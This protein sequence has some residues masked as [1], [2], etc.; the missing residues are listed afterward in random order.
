MSKTCILSFLLLI[1]SISGAESNDFRDIEIR[2]NSL[3]TSTAMYIRLMREV[4][5][6]FQDIGGVRAQDI[7][8]LIA[9][10]DAVIEFSENEVKLAPSSKN[11]RKQLDSTL[12][13][14]KSFISSKQG[15]EL[16]SSSPQS[17]KYTNVP[18]SNLGSS[19]PQ[20]NK[21]KNIPFSNSALTL[22]I[23]ISSPL[24]WEKVTHWY[25]V[26]G[27]VSDPLTEIMVVIHPTEISAFWIQ[28]PVTVK[29]NGT[30][31]VLACF[32][33][34]G[35]DSGM[36][37]EICAFANPVSYFREGRFSNWPESEARSKVVSVIRK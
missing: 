1:T 28:P 10:T 20:S 7:H 8:R 5:N 27:T 35:M 31:K 16:R 4:A 26:K 22:R 13:K 37:F 17:D 25:Y 21:Y 11:Y 19:N 18:F 2:I 12:K 30:W 34:A 33:R 32:G 6:T 24:D 23:T 36:E 14:Y 15:N 29:N 9:I 3:N